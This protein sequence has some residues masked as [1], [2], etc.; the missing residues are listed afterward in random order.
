MF[1]GLAIIMVGFRLVYQSLVGVGPAKNFFNLH[2]TLHHAH[3]IE[4]A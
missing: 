1:W 4:N 2:F 3:L